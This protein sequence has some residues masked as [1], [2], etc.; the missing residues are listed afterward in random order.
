MTTAKLPLGDCEPTEQIAVADWSDLAVLI[1]PSGNKTWAIGTS[2]LIVETAEV[3][4]TGGT[5]KEG[6][7]R[8]E[9]DAQLS[10]NTPGLQGLVTPAPSAEWDALFTWRSDCATQGALRCGSPHWQR[11]RLM[12]VRLTRVAKRPQRLSLDLALAQRSS[13]VP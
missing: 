11:G 2:R 1:T 12:D 8:H 6:V 7:P 13:P 5:S 9:K 3:P 4:V 10:S